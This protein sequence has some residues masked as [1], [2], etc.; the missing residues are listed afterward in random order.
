MAKRPAPNAKQKRVLDAV[1]ACADRY[2][3]G[4]DEVGCGPCAGPLVVAGV[5]AD[6]SWD[7]DLA[8]DSKKLSAKKREKGHDTFLHHTPAG[9]YAVFLASYEAHEIDNITFRA[10]HYELTRLVAT[11]LLTLCRAPV[12]LDGE[13]FP[14]LT[15]SHKN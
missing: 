10:A 2:V 14:A 15:G 11:S 3:I 6:K 5:L 7:H 9:V 4:I 13:L 12:V 1:N 8:R